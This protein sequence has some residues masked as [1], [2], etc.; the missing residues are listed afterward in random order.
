MRITVFSSGGQT[1]LKTVLLFNR[2]LTISRIGRESGW[3][4]LINVKK[5]TSLKLI[6]RTMW[7]HQN[8]VWLKSPPTQ[9]TVISSPYQLNKQIEQ[10]GEFI[11][12]KWMFSHF[13][14]LFI[15]IIVKAQT[16][17]K[18]WRTRGP[19]WCARDRYGLIITLG[20]VGGNLSQTDQNLRNPMCII[21]KI[22][23]LQQNPRLWSENYLNPTEQPW[24]EKFR[25]TPVLLTK[26]THSQT[27][28]NQ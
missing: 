18:L 17:C 6:I 13:W 20:G 7:Y 2:T 21:N 1:Q 4:L 26:S 3:C 14:T 27:F 19:H 10:S 8:S 24:N 11:S 5:L 15:W 22:H 23:P 12:I 25:R 16:K 28:S 9:P